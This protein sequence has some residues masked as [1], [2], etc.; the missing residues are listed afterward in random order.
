MLILKSLTALSHYLFPSFSAVRQTF[1]WRFS[2][3]TTHHCHQCDFVHLYQKTTRCEGFFFFVQ[4]KK[5][6]ADLPQISVTCCTWVWDCHMTKYQQMIQQT[7]LWKNS[8]PVVKVLIAVT[9]CK[10]NYYLSQRFLL[11]VQTQVTQLKILSYSPLPLHF[12]PFYSNKIAILVKVSMLKA[13]YVI[14][15]YEGLFGTTSLFSCFSFGAVQYVTL[16]YSLMENMEYEDV[17][18]ADLFCMCY[19]L[20]NCY[21]GCIWMRFML[22]VVWISWQNGWLSVLLIIWMTWNETSSYGS[23]FYIHLS[24]KS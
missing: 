24:V 9:C 11:S 5:K 19:T 21:S 3:H 23:L 18:L 4:K 10:A 12:L 1:V 16:S 6:S 2:I 14:M 22:Q 13:S 15:W 7:V 20:W 17:Y 8:T